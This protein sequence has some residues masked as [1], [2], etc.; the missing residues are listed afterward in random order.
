MGLEKVIREKKVLVIIEKKPRILIDVSPRSFKI[1]K[2]WAEQAEADDVLL[3]SEENYQKKR[4]PQQS[5]SA[6][7]DD[8]SSSRKEHE[9]QEGSHIEYDQSNLK[10]LKSAISILRKELNDELEKKN[11]KISSLKSLIPD[12][13]QGSYQPNFKTGIMLFRIKTR[14]KN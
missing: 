4:N 10:A 3:F 7:N 14:A 5:S 11:I 12:G 6:D 8:T 13:V 1:L 9:H 2:H